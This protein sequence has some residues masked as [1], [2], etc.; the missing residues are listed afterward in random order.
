MCSVHKTTI[1]QRTRF[2]IDFLSQLLFPQF[3]IVLNIT[4]FSF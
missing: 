3:R 4:Y 1:S 2:Y